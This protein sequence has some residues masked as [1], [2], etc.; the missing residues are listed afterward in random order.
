MLSVCFDIIA[1]PHTFALPVKDILGTSSIKCCPAPSPTTFSFNKAPPL[2]CCED[3][4]IF[5]K[6]MYVPKSIELNL[7]KVVSF[8]AGM[9]LVIML[10]LL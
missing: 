1:Y 10:V 5:E 9:F 8:P 7:I 2:G 4:V 6:I 3:R